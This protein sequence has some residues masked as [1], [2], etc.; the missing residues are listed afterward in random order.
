MNAEQRIARIN[1]KR[2]QAW[3]MVAEREIDITVA[4]LGGPIDDELARR[5]IILVAADLAARRFE[6]MMIVS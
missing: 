1:A 2:D 6:S 4:A 5:C 3:A